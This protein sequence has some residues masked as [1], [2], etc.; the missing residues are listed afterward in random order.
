MTKVAPNREQAYELFREYNKSESLIKH[1]LTVEAVMRHFAEFLGEADVEKWGIIGLVHDIDYE[2]Y[3]EQHCI[4]AREIL[5]ENNWP[6]EY[7]HAVESHGWGL[8]C[9]VEPIE[10]MEKVLYTIDELTGL[11]TATALM[12]PSRSILDTELKSVKKKWKQ[13]GFAAG[14]NR[15]VIEQGANILGMEL[16]NIMEETIKG[17]QKAAE[18]I[19]LKGDSTM[20]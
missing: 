8:C 20:A 2:M 19:G 12:R 7:I 10:K 11:V 18:S 14:V 5:S 6:E 16:D 9:D 13:K 3:P 17:M 1:A 15:E 4:K